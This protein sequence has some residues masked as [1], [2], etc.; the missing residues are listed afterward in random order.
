MEY[1]LSGGW[2]G[3]GGAVLQY[4]EESFWFNNIHY[5]PILIIFDNKNY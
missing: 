1:I 2:G 4:E 5:L 3:V